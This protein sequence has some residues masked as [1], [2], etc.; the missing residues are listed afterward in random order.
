MH[1]A[2]A[3]YSIQVNYLETLVQLPWGEYTPDNLDLK[4]ARD[5]LDEDH[6]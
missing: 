3:E 1:P 2:A 6:S 5:I 4:H